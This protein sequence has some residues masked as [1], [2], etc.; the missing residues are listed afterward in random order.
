MPKNTKNT[1]CSF[2]GGDLGDSFFFN[3]YDPMNKPFICTPCNGK[4]K[5]A[6]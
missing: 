1:V 2:C 5:V 3:L 4:A 6:K